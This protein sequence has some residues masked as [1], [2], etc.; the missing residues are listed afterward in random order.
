M[1]ECLLL[2]TFCSCAPNSSLSLASL[3]NLRWCVAGFSVDT[4]VARTTTVIDSHGT[5]CNTI[6]FVVHRPL[7]SARRRGRT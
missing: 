3:A 6:D 4:G 7:Y 2:R 1:L 5:A